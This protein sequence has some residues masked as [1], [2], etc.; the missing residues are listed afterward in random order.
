MYIYGYSHIDEL[1]GL[2]FRNFWKRGVGTWAITQADTVYICIK[3]YI[4]NSILKLVIDINNSP[5]IIPI[6]VILNYNY[7]PRCIPI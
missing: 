7:I 2:A 3:L 6:P 1:V 4:I 5:I